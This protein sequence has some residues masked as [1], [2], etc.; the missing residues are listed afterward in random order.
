MKRSELGHIPERITLR[1]LQSLKI[2]LY[3]GN[4]EDCDTLYAG[5]A[6]PNAPRGRERFARFG[7]QTVDDGSK[8]S[9]R[10]TLL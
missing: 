10:S 2:G 5:Q 4:R 9:D 7:Q 3:K 1:S 6:A 8:A